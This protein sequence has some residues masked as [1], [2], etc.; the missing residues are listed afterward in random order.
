MLLTY[1]YVKSG[2]KS[3]QEDVNTLDEE[4]FDSDDDSTKNRGES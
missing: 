4:D 2:G 3:L 1:K